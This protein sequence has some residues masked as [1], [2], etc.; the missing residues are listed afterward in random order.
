M[1]DPKRVELADAVALERDATLKKAL[2]IAA[3]L[4]SVIKMSDD[5]AG[6]NSPLDMQGK[7]LFM[8]N[9]VQ[10]NKHRMASLLNEFIDAVNG[11][12]VKP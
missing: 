6:H 11:E 3:L 8:H 7:L 4:Q 10:K 5:V 12:K 1:S 2:A 9:S